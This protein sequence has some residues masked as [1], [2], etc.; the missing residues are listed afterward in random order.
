MLCLLVFFL[1]LFDC[2]T[3]SILDSG[4]GT[5]GLAYNLVDFAFCLQLGAVRYLADGFFDNT[6]YLFFICVI[7]L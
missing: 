6:Y 5:F 1:N 7:L 4:Y 3:R 2:I